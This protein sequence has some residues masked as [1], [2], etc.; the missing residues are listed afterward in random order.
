MILL[1]ILQQIPILCYNYL[2]LPMASTS[3]AAGITFFYWLGYFLGHPFLLIYY[4]ALV[5]VS[6]TENEEAWRAETIIA[7][8]E[9]RGYG[10]LH[11]LDF[12]GIVAL[13]LQQSYWRKCFKGQNKGFKFCTICQIVSAFSSKSQ[14]YV[15]T[16]Y[17]YL[18]LRQVQ[19]P[20]LH[21][22]IVGKVYNWN[23]LL[24][25]PDWSQRIGNN[26]YHTL[27]LRQAQ[28]PVKRSFALGRLNRRE[29]V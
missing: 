21:S 6:Q 18:W 23:S 7:T 9:A 12:G 8:G 20:V 26:I 24:P 10:K 28:P 4:R 14:Y 3:S 2:H 17:I 25:D 27:W 13:F 22:L 19:P 29:A 15:I 1:S 16:I 5:L 11:I